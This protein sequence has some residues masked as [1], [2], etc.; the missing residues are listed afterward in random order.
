[1]VAEVSEAI[2]KLNRSKVS[3]YDNIMTDILKLLGTNEIDILTLI[4]LQT[5]IEFQKSRI[6]VQLYL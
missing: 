5:K 2:R 1:M 6:L 3:G 4:K